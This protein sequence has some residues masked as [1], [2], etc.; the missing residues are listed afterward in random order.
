M[1]QTLLFIKL[2]LV[3][4]TAQSLTET[5]AHC[6]DNVSLKCADDIDSMDF[7]SV[8][9]Y[10]ITDEKKRGIIRRGKGD[11]QTQNYTFPREA[12]FGSGGTYSL[13]LFSVKPG[14]SGT[15]EC[16]ISADIGG[17][18]QNHE[19]KLL[20]HECVTRA[21]LTTATAVLN[22]TL[23]TLPCQQQAEDLPVVWSV[24]GYVAIGLVKIFL[25]VISI[26]VIRIRSSKRRLR[27]W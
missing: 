17:R 24:V 2:L 13:V 15:Y 8:T 18:N 25:C 27:R 1:S 14:D 20:V 3:H 12:K 19:V 6:N 11:S 10:K 22:S 21:E 9:W 26:L 4:H 23:S 5:Q 16:A 7:L